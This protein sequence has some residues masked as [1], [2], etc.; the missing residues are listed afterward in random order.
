MFTECTFRHVKLSTLNPEPQG[1]KRKKKQHLPT[2]SL[3]HSLSPPLPLCISFT[4]SLTLKHA[5]SLSLTLTHS[6][7]HTL[8]HS[9]THTLT[10]THQGVKRK[11]KQ[12]A[13]QRLVDGDFIVCQVMSP[14]YVRL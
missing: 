8:T 7:T 3:P 5:V 12:Q 2:S 14:S 11:K 4:L 10:L 1:V 13:L 9:N 6:H